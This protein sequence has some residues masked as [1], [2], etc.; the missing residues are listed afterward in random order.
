VFVHFKVLEHTT[1]LMIPAN[2]LLFRAQGL[3]VGVVRDGR[4]QL[5]RVVIGKDSGA[6][7]EISSGLKATDAVILDP[8]DSL[9]TG[10]EVQVKNHIDENQTQMKKEAGAQ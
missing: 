7:V 5:V 1:A 8:S 4:V 2:T 9:A 6:N 10:Q 3:Q